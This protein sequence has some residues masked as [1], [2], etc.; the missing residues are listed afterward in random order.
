MKANGL[1]KLLDRIENGLKYDHYRGKK[2]GMWEYVLAE[3]F[4]LKSYSEKDLQADIKKLKDF[5]AKGFDLY[6]RSFFGLTIHES[7]SAC[8]VPLSSKLRWVTYRIES[9]VTTKYK[10][11]TDKNLGHT[12]VFVGGEY[13]GYL[14]ANKVGVRYTFTSKHDSYSHLSNEKRKPLLAQINEKAIIANEF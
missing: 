2:D 5:R 4:K 8:A 9:R 6:D 14:M 3:K 13:I 10:R 7:I 12:D 11:P 1:Y